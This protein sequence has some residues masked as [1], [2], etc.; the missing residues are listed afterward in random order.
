MLTYETI[1]ILC[2]K[3]GVAVTAVERELGFA[4]GS[5]CKVN[6][7]KPSME[8]VQ[9]LAEYFQVSVDYL[10]TGEAKEKTP[11]LTERDKRDIAKDLD[12]IMR[13]LTSGESGPASYDGEPLSPDAA[14]LFRDEL[15]IALKRLKIMNK[16]TYTPKKYKK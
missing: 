8:K 7:S 12:N 2:K 4:R 14:A 10:L 3:K 13:K 11:E 15:E 6:T 1:K 9:K 16:E 5:L